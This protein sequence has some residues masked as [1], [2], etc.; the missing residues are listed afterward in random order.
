MSTEDQ[1][2]MDLFTLVLGILVAMTFAIFLLA[3]FTAGST[4]QEWRREGADFQQ[5]VLDRIRP[6]GQV[7]LPGDA[8]DGEEPV[9]EAVAAAPVAE[10]MSGPQVYNTACLACHGTG[11]GGAPTLG[12]VA[13]WVPRLAQGPDILADHVINGYTGDA[14]YMPPKGGRIDLSDEEILAAMNYLLDESK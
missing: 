7:A 9:A 12:D 11:V 14:G 5:Q 6:I 4:Q 1:S 3:R 8:A 10:V 13:A 2:F